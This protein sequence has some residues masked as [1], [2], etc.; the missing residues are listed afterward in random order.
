VTSTAVVCRSTVGREKVLW[1]GSAKCATAAVCWHGSDYFCSLA[2]ILAEIREG[3]EAKIESVAI[4]FHLQGT[5]QHTQLSAPR[6]H[7]HGRRQISTA[8]HYHTH[9][10]ETH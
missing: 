4:L 7:V 2:A 10:P 8:P 3:A 6:V 9:L 1:H 5:F